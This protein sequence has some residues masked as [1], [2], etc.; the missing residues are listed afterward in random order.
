MKVIEQTNNRIY[1][2]DKLPE[3]NESETE[4]ATCHE[5][6]SWALNWLS[7]DMTGI[8]RA[9]PEA[10]LALQAI[11]TKLVRCIMIVDHPDCYFIL[12]QMRSTFRHLKAE[13]EI[14]P[15]TVIRPFTESDVEPK[16]EEADSM[17]GTVESANVEIGMEVA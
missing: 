7:K 16:N 5:S 14:G 3:L 6:L 2:K 12:Q 1:I 15:Y 9:F 17:K 13:L 8:A 10:G 11:S 4:Q